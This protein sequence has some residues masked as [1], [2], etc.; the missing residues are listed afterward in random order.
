MP[1]GEE[2]DTDTT[3]EEKRIIELKREKRTRKTAVT[4]TRHNL[5]RLSAK[6]GDCELIQGEINALWE[7]FERSLVI[8]DELQTRYLHLKQNENKKSVEDEIEA[9]EKEVN[10]AI[11]KAERVV[12]DILEGKQAETNEQSLQQTPP[13]K[14][15]YSIH[16]PG[17]S[18]SHH[19]SSCNQRLKPLKVPVFSGE[20]SKFEDF[21]EM[22]LSLVDQSE[23][24]PNM[25]MARLRQSLSGT[26]FEAIRGLGVT[27]PEYN[28]AKKILQSKF[29]GERRK[30]QAYMDQIEQMPPLKSTDV[31]S[32]E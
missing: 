9:L 8:M 17:S 4:K 10:T 21:W 13:P 1:L 26:V 24:P 3:M 29:G 11:E 15:P 22:F 12:K 16:S 31:K 28:E 19:S 14:S 5:E 18:H 27:E 23:E 25:K 7:V 30:L 6:R 2:D 20:K 32:F